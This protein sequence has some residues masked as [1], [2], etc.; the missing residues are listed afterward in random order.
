MVRSGK[1]LLAISNDILD[2]AKVESGK[3]NLKRAPVSPAEVA[4]TV[5]TLFI[6]R[7]RAPPSSA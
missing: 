2:I 4:D 6:E 1:S 3:L 5:V 7:A